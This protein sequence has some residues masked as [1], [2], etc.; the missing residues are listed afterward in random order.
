MEEKRSF[1]IVI[2]LT[3]SQQLFFSSNRVLDDVW[4]NCLIVPYILCYKTSNMKRGRGMLVTC[5]Y[6]PDSFF[7]HWRRRRNKHNQGIHT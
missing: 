3:L 5:T 6:S 2:I 1:L 4:D 7:I